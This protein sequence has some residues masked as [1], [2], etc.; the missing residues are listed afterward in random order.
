M[1]YASTRCLGGDLRHMVGVVELLTVPQDDHLSKLD[2]PSSTYMEDACCV[3]ISERCDGGGTAVQSPPV[4]IE[5]DA[6]SVEQ[7]SVMADFLLEE[8]WRSA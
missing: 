3:S 2:A 7:Y 6:L 1:Y 4:E 8:S 5:E